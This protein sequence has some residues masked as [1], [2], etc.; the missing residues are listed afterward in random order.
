MNEHIF[1]RL[2][3]FSLKSYFNAKSVLNEN[4]AFVFS[5]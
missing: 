5:L 3:I 4:S 1:E 2:V